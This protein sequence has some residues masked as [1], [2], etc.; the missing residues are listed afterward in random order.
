MA[1]SIFS[2]DFSSK[3]TTF[4]RDFFPADSRFS[5]SFIWCSMSILRT[6]QEIRYVHCLDS[7]IVP[8]GKFVCCENKFGVIIRYFKQAAIFSLFCLFRV[9]LL[10]HLNIDFFVLSD[11]YKINLAISGFPH[12]DSISPSAEF[13]IYD[14]FKAGSNAVCVIA[15]NTVSQG[16]IGQIEFFPAFSGVPSL[17]SYLNSGEA[18][19]PFP[20]FQ[21]AVNRFVVEGSP[22]CFQV[23][24]NGLGGKV[25]PTL[26][27]VY[28]TTRSN[29]SIFRT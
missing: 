19:M 27:N 18:D 2:R 1:I 10:R 24:C 28:F 13:Q 12:I 11:C 8:T 7:L 26:L 22:F 23:I 17:Q 21:I 3:V 4:S 29:W 16:N 6:E 15:E 25:L 14:I 9:D 20:A 5:L